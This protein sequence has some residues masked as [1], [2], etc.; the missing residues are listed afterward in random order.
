MTRV[1]IVT[2]ALLLPGVA[3]A[4]TSHTK[5]VPDTWGSQLQ[6]IVDQARRVW[7]RLVAMSTKAQTETRQIATAK[8]STR[9]VLETRSPAL[10]RVHRLF[11]DLSLNPRHIIR[12]KVRG[13]RPGNRYYAGYKIQDGIKSPTLIG[14]PA[15]PITAASWERL[16]VSTDGR[17]LITTMIQPEDHPVGVSGQRVVTMD[18]ARRAFPEADIRKGVKDAFTD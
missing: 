17:L 6:R 18:Q 7:T 4:G 14:N 10:E 16:E 15:D 2:V 5:N 11:G 9:R 1:V 12:V 8:K 3:S 13:R